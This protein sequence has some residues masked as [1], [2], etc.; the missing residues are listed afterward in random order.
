VVKKE[1]IAEE[2]H[3][4]VDRADLTENDLRELLALFYRYE[5]DMEQFSV[6]LDENN[7]DWFFENREAF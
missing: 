4:Y 2:L 1:G 5:I 6:F 3:I 7:K